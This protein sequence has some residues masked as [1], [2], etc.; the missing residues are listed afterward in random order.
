MRFI[1]K[2]FNKEI[3]LKTFRKEIII[4]E[5]TYIIDISV[6]DKDW[7]YCNLRNKKSRK[8][9]YYNTYDYKSYVKK[10]KENAIL[11]MAQDFLSDYKKLC[12]IAI[13][14][15]HFSKDEKFDNWNGSL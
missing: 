12:D 3:E 10:Y 7:A 15:C 4:D 13:G 8:T 5:E 2:W 1:K 14:N 9:N 6:Y 11:R